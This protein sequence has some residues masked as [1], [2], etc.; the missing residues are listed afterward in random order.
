MDYELLRHFQELRPYEK[1]LHDHL[2]S[3]GTPCVVGPE[4][5]P[6]TK[7]ERQIRILQQ[8]RFLQVTE[9]SHNYVEMI[10]MYSGHGIYR[11]NGIEIT[12]RTGDLLLLSQLAQHENQA[13][14]EHDIIINFI[15]SPLF[16]ELTLGMMGDTESSLRDFL[17]DCLRDKEQVGR[18]IHFKVADVLP[19]QALLESMIWS[20]TNKVHYHYNINQISLGLLFLHLLSHTEKAH[21]SS[22]KDKQIF[23]IL[24]YIEEN[25]VDGT[26]IELAELLAYDV[27]W[28][29]KNIKNLTGSNFEDLRQNRRIEQAK[30]LLRTTTLTIPE[31]TNQIG[32]SNS[33]YFYQLFRKRV[34]SSPLSYRKMNT[35]NECA[36]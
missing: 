2:L 20:L 34:G 17:I 31:I 12:L 28:L 1:D 24:Q 27:Y 4:P 23:T 29:S 33:G 19:I 18:H 13:P 21:L 32:Y 3:H 7:V 5:G 10:Y 26:L 36:V 30:F 14:G 15:V 9:H 8:T 35:T 16:F 6:Y 22:K 25:Y 11:A